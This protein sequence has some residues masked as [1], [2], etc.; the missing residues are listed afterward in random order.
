MVK[1]T[2]A[3]YIVTNEKKV[4]KLKA[5]LAD[6]NFLDDLELFLKKDNLR[7]LA[8]TDPSTAEAAQDLV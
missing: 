1:R 8:E 5:E 6:T 7:F 3:K 4:S 2:N